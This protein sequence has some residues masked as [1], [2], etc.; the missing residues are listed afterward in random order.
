[1]VRRLGAVNV[2]L[3]A[4]DAEGDGPFLPEGGDTLGRLGG[5]VEPLSERGSPRSGRGRRRRSRSLQEADARSPPSSGRCARPG[6]SLP[7]S[8]RLASAGRLA[9]GVAH[10]VEIGAHA[11]IAYAALLASGWRGLKP[12]QARRARGQF[13]ERNRARGGPRRIAILRGLLYLARPREPAPGAARARAGARRARA[14]WSAPSRCSSIYDLVASPRGLPRVL[15]EEDDY[16]VQVLVNLFTNAAQAG[17]RTVR[18][19]ASAGEDAVLLG[20]ADDGRGIA[21]EILP[22]LFEPFVTTASPGEGTGLGLALS[23]ATMERIGGS[24][25]HPRRR[26]RGTIFSLRFRRAP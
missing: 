6:P 18:V 2:A 17:A 20:I 1:M 19:A 16:V 15:G 24:I 25:R 11:V 9:A 10:E 22:R 21:P 8:E 26:A 7:R 23:H 3:G 12:G 14:R 13:A 5:A 4:L